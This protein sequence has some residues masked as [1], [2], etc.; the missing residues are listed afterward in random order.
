MWSTK[1][2]PISALLVVLAMSLLLATAVG[3]VARAQVPHLSDNARIAFGVPFAIALV[4]EI[5]QVKTGD[6]NTLAFEVVSI[7]PNNTAD[8]RF[9]S[10]F[11][12]TG[13]MAR[14]VDFHMVNRQAFGLQESQIFREPDWVRSAKY[15]IDAK[16]AESDT[17]QLN[18]L[19]L[20]ERAQMLRPMFVERL[21]M[22]YHYEMKSLPVFTLVIA[23]GGAKLTRT[24]AEDDPKWTKGPNGSGRSWMVFNGAGQVTGQ[25]VPISSLIQMLSQQNLGRVIVDETGLTGAYNFVLAWDPEEGMSPG[26]GATAAS[27]AKPSIFTALQEQLGL[28]LIQRNKPIE[29]LVID[30]IERPAPN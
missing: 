13:L 18:S 9:A 22:R 30:H 11:T 4:Q 23:K 24:G 14:N 21:R 27:G 15:D 1:N 12:P 2:M 28:K 3:S 6:A 20:P 16:V 8:S 7:K 17:A 29:T 10:H 5:P 25:A 19:S 26:S